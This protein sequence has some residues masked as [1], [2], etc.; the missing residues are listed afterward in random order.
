[1][2]K[3]LVASIA[4]ASLCG[5]PALAADMPTKAPVY[6]AAVSP[7]FS[8]TGFYAGLN[9]G[10]G[11]GRTGE[12]VQL[13]VPETNTRGWFFGGQVGYNHQ[14]A[15][16]WLVGVQADIDWS[17]IRGQVIEVEAGIDEI[18]KANV[19]YFGTVRARVGVTQGRTLFY[20]TGGFAFGHNSVTA[21]IAPTFF[22]ASENHTGWAGGGGVEIA[23][24]DKDSIV[25]E[26]V[27]I[28]LGT[29]NYDLGGP[30]GIQPIHVRFNTVRAAWNHHF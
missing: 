23:L 11:W 20:G 12:A 10:Y 30:Y 25:I 13:D 8:W 15:N 26:D 17:R 28:D 22:S 7:L 14:F 24:S 1:M 27:Y 4:A 18:Y 3:I 29:K 6:K 16:Y 9:G 21:G 19:S 2:K 5:A